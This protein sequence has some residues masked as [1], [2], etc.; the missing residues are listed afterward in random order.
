MPPAC[1]ISVVLSARNGQAEVVPS[2][3]STLAALGPDDEIVA[4][5]DGS[6]DETHARMQAILAGHPHQLLKTSGLGLT[7][8]LRLGLDATR[9]ELIARLDAGD[10]MTPDRLERQHAEFARDPDLVV[11]GGNVRFVDDDGR[12]LGR[13]AF[14][15]TDLG[16]KVCLAVLSNAFVHSTLCLRRSKMVEAGGYRELFTYAQ[17]FDLLLRIS[18]LGTMRNVADVLGDYLVSSK[19]ISATKAVEQYTFARMAWKEHVA[20][21]LGRR[22][23]PPVVRE[24]LSAWRRARIQVMR[25]LRDDIA[26]ARRRGEL[27]RARTLEMAL[28]C[29]SPVTTLVGA[30]VRGAE[31]VTGVAAT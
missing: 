21:L 29:C 31:R 13:S 11:C 27:G 26:T 15:T 25:R 2:L 16:I 28:R 22:T 20:T 5:D 24:E 14:P 19:S 7:R 4:I 10:T 18:R 3:Q 6:T 17:D 23:S 12:V 9:G 8:A 30:T 1:R